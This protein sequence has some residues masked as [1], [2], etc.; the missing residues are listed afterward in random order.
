[1]AFKEQ[2]RLGQVWQPWYAALLQQAG[3]RAENIQKRQRLGPRKEV[4]LVRVS[5]HRVVCRQSRGS[6]FRSPAGLLPVG[7]PLLCA[8]RLSMQSRALVDEECAASLEEQAG[9]VLC[10]PPAILLCSR[11]DKHSKGLLG[12]CVHAACCPM[13]NRC[14]FPVSCCI[15]GCHL[16]LRQPCWLPADEAAWRC[17]HL[18]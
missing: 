16:S 15:S 12:F 18:Q 1:M 13:L 17:C 3:L 14:I 7:D 10:Q 6:R 2:V 5:P 4:R 8:L 11:N 9:A